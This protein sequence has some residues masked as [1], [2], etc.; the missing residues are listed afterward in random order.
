MRAPQCLTKDR[1]VRIIEI[2]LSP[3]MASRVDAQE[4]ISG[5]I[6]PQH[7]SPNH[8]LNHFDV[9]LQASDRA[10]NVPS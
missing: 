3:N 4:L 6:G 8:Y 9:H 10:L 7:C 2:F 5:L 1:I